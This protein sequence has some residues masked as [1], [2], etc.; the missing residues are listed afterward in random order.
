MAPENINEAKTQLDQILNQL[1]QHKPQ[2]ISLLEWKDIKQ[3]SFEQYASSARSQAVLLSSFALHPV[4]SPADMLDVG[5]AVGFPKTQEMGL[6]L[7][8]FM[9]PSAIT[10]EIVWLP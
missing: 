9:S 7:A 2:E 3:G 5:K 8:Q 6:A 10:T 1:A 4:D